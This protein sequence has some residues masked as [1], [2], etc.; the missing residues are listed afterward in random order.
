LLYASLNQNKFVY[1][2]FEIE[3]VKI[4][5]GLPK[6]QEARTWSGYGFSRSKKLLKYRNSCSPKCDI[7]LK[8]KKNWVWFFNKKN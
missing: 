6:L 3:A 1:F 2:I 8:N 5:K 7:F 4:L